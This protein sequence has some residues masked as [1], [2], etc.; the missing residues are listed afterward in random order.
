M[1]VKASLLQ[2]SNTLLKGICRR[3]KR[4]HIDVCP[5]DRLCSKQARK[6][7]I[8]FAGLNALESLI[9]ARIYGGMLDG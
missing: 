4:L 8:T 5:H 9:V 3:Q 6:E 1:N 2:A 7:L